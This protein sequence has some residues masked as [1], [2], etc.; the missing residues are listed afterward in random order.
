[1]AAFTAQIDRYAEDPAPAIRE[2]VASALVN[3]G[4]TLGQ[5]GRSDEEI[6]VYDQ[7][8][9]SYA[10]DPAP[11]IREQ[12]AKAMSNASQIDFSRGLDEQGAARAR[13]ALRLAGDN[14]DLDPMRAEAH[15]YLFAHHPG[16][17]AA[18]GA[19]LKTL[20]ATGVSTGDWSFQPNLDRLGVMSREVVQPG[21]GCRSPDC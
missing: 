10:E 2:Q 4:V 15:L 20:L 11:A 18:A 1:L 14:P 12:V 16:S 21:D 3:K 17:R 5:A 6:G 7:L 8:I 13:E 9:T 19:A